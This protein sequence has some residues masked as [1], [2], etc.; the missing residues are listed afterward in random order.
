MTCRDV[1]RVARLRVEPGRQ[2]LAQMGP[3]EPDHAR[4]PRHPRE[5]GRLHEALQV[6]RHVVA[7]APQLADRAE[8]GAPPPAVHRHPPADDRH[9]VEHRRVATSTS[10]SICASGIPLAQRRRHGQRVH[11][12]AEGAEADDQDLHR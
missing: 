1:A 8:R 2:P 9:E 4:R 5:R 11:D 3:R 7:L 12:V 6:H 10:Q